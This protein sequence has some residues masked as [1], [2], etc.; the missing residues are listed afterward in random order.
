[1]KNT[2]IAIVEDEWTV[3]EEMK[4]VLQS[5]QYDV[6]SMDLSG[7]EAIR[8]VEK[9]KPDLVLMDIVLEGEMDGIETANEI[10]SRFNIPIIYL[11]AYTDEKI[12]ERA[13][14]T[15]PFGYIVKPFVNEDLK[16][17]IEIAMYKYR[18]ELERKR[19][20]EELYGALP[21]ITSLSGL[22][23]VCP[24]CKKVR[25]AEGNWK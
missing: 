1:M 16:I 8:N 15:G 17:S 2:R 3:A 19:F 14:V 20:I 13:S 7:E 22:L 4:M 11:T 25:D 12:L 5:M 24:S 6:T 21:N 18:I 9:D 23:P 10:R